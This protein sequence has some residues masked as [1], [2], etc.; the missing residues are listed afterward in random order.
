MCAEILM[1]V[2]YT[3]LK[4]ECTG[5]A[6]KYAISLKILEIYE[7]FMFL[8]MH[9]CEVCVGVCVGCVYVC[10]GGV[11]VCEQ[12]QLG[13]IIKKIPQQNFKF[14][15]LCNNRKTIC[16]VLCKVQITNLVVE[17]QW[18]YDTFLLT[19]MPGSFLALRRNLWDEYAI[20]Y[21]SA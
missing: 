5:Q 7:G 17:K 14:Y 10:G 15:S 11:F 19:S 6:S 4:G 9:G 8:Y 1:L 18:P 3:N 20:L 21:E 12:Q 13:Y 2:Q 16:K